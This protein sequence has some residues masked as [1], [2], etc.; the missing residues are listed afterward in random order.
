MNFGLGIIGLLLACLLVTLCKKRTFDAGNVGRYDV[1]FLVYSCKPGL[2]GRDVVFIARG[3]I[4]YLSSVLEVTARAFGTGWKAYGRICMT[5]NSCTTNDERCLANH[6]L[7]RTCS[8][9]RQWNKSRLMEYILDA[10][11]PSDH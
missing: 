5:R 7:G 11:V 10:A 2:R 1:G 4:V 9:S 8:A 3:G 6:A